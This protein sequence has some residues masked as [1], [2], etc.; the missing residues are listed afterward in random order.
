MR[1]DASALGLVL[2]VA[3]GGGCGG[4]GSSA[5]DG[6]TQVPP[7]SSDLPGDR[8]LSSLTADE[9]A[10]LCTRAF[11]YYDRTQV[12]QN[13]CKAQAPY[14][15]RLTNP[16]SDDALRAACNSCYVSCVASMTQPP[17]LMTCG[18]LSPALACSG[19]IAEYEACL[20]AL[21]DGYAAAARSS[22]SCDE[23]TVDGGAT[24]AAAGEDP[25]QR[26]A[27]KCPGV[28]FPGRGTIASCGAP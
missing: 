8:A 9:W 27:Q 22:S 24:S 28:M 6:A 16:A 4:G 3:A 2:I 17:V 13:L 20:T 19:T 15:A 12:S 11:A 14:S 21:V 25:C 7:F 1:A 26:L 23:L 18:G 5:T 10:A